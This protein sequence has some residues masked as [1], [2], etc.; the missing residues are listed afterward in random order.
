M[1]LNKKYHAFNWHNTTAQ[2]ILLAEVSRASQRSWHLNWIDEYAFSRDLD[3]VD[4][5]KHTRYHPNLYKFLSRPV[6]TQL[7]IWFSQTHH[8]ILKQM[9]ELLSKVML[10]IPKGKVIASSFHNITHR[11]IKEVHA[12]HCKNL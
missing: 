7:F 5:L 9:S 1:L 2:S 3:L 10:K 8:Q 12:L 6:L 4:Y 11:I